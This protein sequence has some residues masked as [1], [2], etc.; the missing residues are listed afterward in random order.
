MTQMKRFLLFCWLFWCALP[1]V[2]SAACR[3]VTGDR[4]LG[5]DL[6]QANPAFAAL[7]ALAQFG[8]AP[9][10][11]STRT[12]PVTELQRIARANGIAL[13]NP[14][15]ICFE[16]PLHPPSESDFADAMRRSLPSAAAVRIVDMTHAP[17]PTGR[18]DFPLSGLEPAATGNGGIE[19]WRGFVQ[20]T[21]TR[22]VAVW[23]RV[24]VRVEYRAVVLRHDV[25][26]GTMIDETA[27][28]VDTR[29]GSPRHET[30]AGAMAAGIED[31]AGRALRQP[32]RAGAE[33]PLALLIESP[34]VHRGESVHVEIQSGSALL[35]FEAIA[36][37][38]ARA[39]ELTD[40]RNPLTGKTFR[41]RILAG[42]SPAEFKA[43]IN[44]GGPVP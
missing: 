17:L 30:I 41:A 29:T 24:S 21:E 37:T 27:L 5:R 9:A 23:A 6:A 18:I 22:R 31:V 19:M 35:R 20:Y 13:D 4:I 26:A 15:E 16:I 36:Q 3:P 40:M 44:V 43:V 11:G 28:R 14:G 34:A 2:L 33:V 39:G 32:L 8:Y 25:P 7:P 42:S 12:L 38:D 10:P 1:A